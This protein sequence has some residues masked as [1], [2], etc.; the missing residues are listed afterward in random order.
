M[1]LAEQDKEREY[2]EAA[3]SRAERNRDSHLAR[4]RRL[5]SPV[6]EVSDAIGDGKT[7]LENYTIVLSN[8]DR[9]FKCRFHS[10]TT[11]NE[12]PDLPTNDDLVN[13]FQDLK[14]AQDQVDEAIETVRLLNRSGK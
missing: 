5:L 2:A 9:P 11:H 14:K 3:L 10:K 6:K 7:A 1:T 13:A 4:W 8:T 12:L